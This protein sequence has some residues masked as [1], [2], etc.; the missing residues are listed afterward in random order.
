MQSQLQNRHQRLL[1]VL[2]TQSNKGGLIMEK[3]L[4]FKKFHPDFEGDLNQFA[5]F[6][7]G[8]EFSVSSFY[9]ATLNDGR[10][11]WTLKIC[12]GDFTVTIFSNEFALVREL[13]TDLRA[14]ADFFYSRYIIELPFPRFFEST[15]NN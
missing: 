13:L 8:S 12:K 6:I 14:L 7:S 2:H 1:R 3:E 4:I 10:Y 5:Y 11:Y 15:E 9:V